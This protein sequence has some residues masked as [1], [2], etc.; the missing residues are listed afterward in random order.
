MNR[1]IT[2]SMAT[3]GLSAL[4]ASCGISP[5]GGRADKQK[6]TADATNSTSGDP[7][8]QS[9]VCAPTG[10]AALAESEVTYEGDIKPIVDAK[11][12]WCHSAT[13][14]PANR[15]RPYLTTYEQ[16]AGESGDSSEKMRQGEM[17]P[18]GKDPVLTADDLALFELWLAQG[19]VRGTP[20]PPID[21]T[22]PVYYLDTVKQLLQAR[23]TGCH[24][25]GGTP[26]QL[27]TYAN[28]VA[29]ATAS[30]SAIQAGRMPKAGPLAADEQTAF[31]AW[32]DAGTPYDGTG[33][34]PPAEETATNTQATCP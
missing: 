10:T 29:N 11:C 28:A 2:R 1:S 22:A 15:E 3:L 19:K 21:A 18:R 16:V 9:E 5:S 13:A 26:P 4:I 34:T 20:R 30:L 17:P 33:A 31:S 24:S 27:D 32:I 8:S 6:T 25:A 12:A 7:A 23:C 14:S